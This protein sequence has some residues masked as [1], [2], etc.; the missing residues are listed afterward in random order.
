MIRR[1]LIVA[2]AI[3]FVSLAQAEDKSSAS[4]LSASAIRI[5]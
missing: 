1:S 4:K 5:E 3:L 2:C